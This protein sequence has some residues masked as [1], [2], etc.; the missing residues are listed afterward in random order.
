M[1][2]GSKSA[3]FIH[4]SN[5]SIVDSKQV[6]AGWEC[7]YYNPSKSYSFMSTTTPLT[8]EDQDDPEMMSKMLTV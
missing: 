8:N 6:T 7:C 3:D 5:A 4:C 2:T 1:F